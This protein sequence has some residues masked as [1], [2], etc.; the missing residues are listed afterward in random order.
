[1]NRW[2]REMSCAVAICAALLVPM[3]AQSAPAFTAEDIGY[4]IPI[5][6]NAAGAILGVDSYGGTQPWV[7][8]GAAKIPLPLPAGATGAQANRIGVG[9]AVAGQIG[10]QAVV[11]WPSGTGGYVVELLPFPPGATVGNAVKVDASGEV[12]VSYG[13]PTRLVTGLTVWS[14]KPWLYRP[15]AGLMDPAPA[16]ASL[17]VAKDF[18]DAGR[19]LL[20]SGEIVETSGVVT[21]A[22]AF[23]PRPPGGP[24][25]TFFRAARINEAGAFVGVATLSTSQNYAQVARFTPG[26]GWQTLGGLSINV[27]ARGIDADGNALMMVN[28]VCP[29]AFGLAYNQPGGS[30][31]CLDDLIVGGG[32]SFTSLSSGGVIVSSGLPGSGAGAIVALGY[33]VAAR[34]YRLARLDVGGTLPPPPAVTL[35]A[36]SHPATWQQPYDSIHLTWTP[37]GELGKGYIIERRSPGSASFVEIARLGPTY[38]QYDDTA[39]TPL[40]TYNYRMAVIGL[41]GIGPYSNVATAVAPPPMDRTAPTATITEPAAGTTVSGSAIVSATFADNVGVTYARLSFSPTLGNEVICARAPSAPAA[42]LTLTCRWD[43]RSVAYR[44][45]TATITAY[46]QDAIGNY[47]ER[48]VNVNVTYRRR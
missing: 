1:M 46:A 8:S 21:P 7:R 12:L 22:P 2:M 38:A 43:T 47:V 17:A 15:G 23:P 44:S 20:E 10:T 36:T 16:Y 24:G 45:P 11:W 39:I 37:A 13:T 3:T 14:Y 31:Y 29:S 5:D 18:T 32:W 27:S 30:T 9:G 26:S 48:S 25:W 33:N 4:G 34:A 42:T 19:I 40:A 6:V 41:G 35:T 28:Y